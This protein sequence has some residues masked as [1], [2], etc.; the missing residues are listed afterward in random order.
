[1]QM[2]IAAMGGDYDGKAELPA[3]SQLREISHAEID[4]VSG[5]D[6]LLADAKDVGHWTLVIER[7]IGELRR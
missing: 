5:D 1:M 7:Q 4:S 2:L 3:S 6:M